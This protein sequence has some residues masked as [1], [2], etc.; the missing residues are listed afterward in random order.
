M[1]FRR[2]GARFD[3]FL[4]RFQRNANNNWKIPQIIW[5]P[6]ICG[7]LLQFLLGI[8]CIRMEIGRNIFACLGN[9]VATFLNYTING[10]K[11]V[12]GDFLVIEK[13]VFAFS[14]S[15]IAY[16][17][18][19]FF[20]NFIWFSR[21]SRCCR[22]YFSSVSLFQCCTTGTPCNGL[23]KN[24]AGFCNRSSARLFARAL[25]LLGIFF[26]AWLNHRF[27]FDHTFRYISNQATSIYI[28]SHFGPWIVFD[29]I[30]VACNHGFWVC[31]SIWNSIGCVHIVW[32][33]S[34]TFN[35]FECDGRSCRFGIFEIIFSRSRR[36]Q[37]EIRQYCR[38]KIVS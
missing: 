13:G 29:S 32:S 37:N 18:A 30:R 6:V 1:C 2:T 34:I 38:G 19:K 12:F 25:P 28:D 15:S 36:E 11:F 24:W 7:A 35:H 33:R 8:F 10:S 27:W 3:L 26:L 31:H 20:L 22:L 17:L 23:C 14:V 21:V 5:R 4:P 9:K 16:F